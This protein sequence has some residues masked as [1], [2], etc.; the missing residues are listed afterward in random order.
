MAPEGPYYV[1]LP[2][3]QVPLENN[4]HIIVR[5]ARHN[6]RAK[7]AML[8]VTSSR[9]GRRQYKIVVNEVPSIVDEAPTTIYA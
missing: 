5:A 4:C 8:D 6:A 2:I 3:C 1:V 7:Q 9:E